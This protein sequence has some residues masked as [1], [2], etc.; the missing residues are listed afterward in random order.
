MAVKSTLTVSIGRVGKIEPFSVMPGSKSATSR[1]C[2]LAVVYSV[3]D[4]KKNQYLTVK[5]MRPPEDETE[6]IDGGVQKRLSRK[7]RQP[8]SV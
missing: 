8:A 4:A 5:V 1:W 7:L 6:V 2:A 3:R